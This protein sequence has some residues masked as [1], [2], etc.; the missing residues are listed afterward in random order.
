MTAAAAS[1]SL[2]AHSRMSTSCWLTDARPSIEPN[3]SISAR[4]ITGVNCSPP[5][6]PRATA[7]REPA[8]FDPP[9]VPQAERNDLLAL[10]RVRG[11][12]AGEH[13]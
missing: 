9:A 8:W 6:T 3:R 1:A 2:A 5:P 13:R 7:R 4:R 12:V 11:Q 10:H